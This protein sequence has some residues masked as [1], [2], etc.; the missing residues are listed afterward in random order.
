MKFDRGIALCG[1]ACVLG[2]DPLRALFL[3]FALL[4]VFHL[5]DKIGERR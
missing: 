2:K 3:F 5:T 1:I 4:W